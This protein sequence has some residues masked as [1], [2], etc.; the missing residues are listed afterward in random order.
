MVVLD[1]EAVRDVVVERNLHLVLGVQAQPLPAVNTGAAEVARGV[2]EAGVL[3]GDAAVAPVGQARGELVGALVAGLDGGAA[4]LAAVGSH[5][6][7]SAVLHLV[8]S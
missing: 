8:L 7:P 5:L 2:R 6:H 4:A 3:D 1:H